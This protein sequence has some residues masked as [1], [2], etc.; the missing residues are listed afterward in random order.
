MEQRMSIIGLGVRDLS[1]S[2]KFYTETMGWRETDH[3]GSENI[4]FIQLNGIALS[5]YPRDALA[6]DA[7]ISPDGSGFA[8][9]SLAHNTRSKDEVDEILASIESKGGNIVKPAEEVFWGGYSGYFSDPDNYLWEVA[10]NP[11]ATVDDDGNFVISA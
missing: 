1:V 9:I 3:P 11:F 7:K 10:W 4:A 2:R 8:G 6:E 5:L